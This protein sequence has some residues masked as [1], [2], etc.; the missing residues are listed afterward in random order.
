MAKLIAVVD[1]ESSILALV[2]ASLVPEGFN[3]EGFGRAEEL[4]RFLDTSSPDA[5][6]LDIMM[7]EMDGFEACRA[8]RAHQRT[9]SIPILFLSA[10]DDV[11]DKIVGLEIGAD[12]YLTKPFH[13]RELAARVRA[14]VRRTKLSED[15][16]LRRVGSLEL[17]YGTMEAR[18]LDQKLDLTATEFRLLS[19]LCEHPGAVFSRGQLLDHLWEDTRIVTDRTIDAHI[20][21]IRRKLGQCASLLRTMRGAGYKIEA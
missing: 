1:D 18:C 5:I 13:P 9:A 11:I 12:D 8:L 10:K 19:I 15:S 17:D 3:V 6:I 4:F 2:K 14:L 16:P 7:P 20:V 21:R